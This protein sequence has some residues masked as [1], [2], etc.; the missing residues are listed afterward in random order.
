MGLIAVEGI[1]QIANLFIAI[2]AG[3]IA[4]TLFKRAWKTEKLK[5]WVPLIFALILFAFQQIIAA[6]RSFHIYSTPYLTHIVPTLILGCLITAVILE[7][8]VKRRGIK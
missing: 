2:A 5:A 7:I 3:I 4:S 8:D 1:F 6:L